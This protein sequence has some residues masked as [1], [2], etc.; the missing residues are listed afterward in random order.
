M[1]YINFGYHLLQSDMDKF[2]KVQADF[3]E[4]LKFLSIY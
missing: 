3:A 1:E 4:C 2:S